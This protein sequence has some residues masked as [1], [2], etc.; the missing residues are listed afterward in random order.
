M[1]LY[2]GATVCECLKW[3]VESINGPEQGEI[4]IFVDN[5]GT[6]NI[7]SNPVQSGRNLHVHARYFY[8]RDLVYENEILVVHLPTDEQV[9][10]AGCTFKGGPVFLKLRDYLMNCARVMHDESGIP[11]WE[12]HLQSLNERKQE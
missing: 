1:A 7:A 2:V 10:D 4:Q 6:I 12:F 5:T 3:L 9:A 11:R 8:V